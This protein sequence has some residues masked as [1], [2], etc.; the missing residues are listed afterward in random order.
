MI[1]SAYKNLIDLNPLVRVVIALIAGIVVGDCYSDAY[2]SWLWWL[3]LVVCLLLLLIMRGRKLPLCATPVK[4]SVLLLVA[5]FFLGGFLTV[6]HER[7]IEVEWPERNLSYEAICLSEPSVHGKVARVDLCIVRMDTTLLYE[8]IKVRAN[9]LRDT[10]TRRWSSLHVGDGIS[11]R[12]VLESPSNYR[13][14]TFDYVRWLKCHGFAGQ[15]FIYYTDWRQA[16]VSTIRLSSWQRVRLRSLRLRHKLLD[17]YRSMQ[18]E[19][20]AYG[21]IAAMTLGDKSSVDR[22]VKDQYSVS[23]GSHILALSGLHLSI[24]Y[25]LL[26]LLLGSGYRLMWLRQLIILIAVWTFVV[27][28][29]LPSSAVRSAVMLSLCSICMVGQRARVTVNALAF[30][31]IV[32]LLANPLTLWDIGFQMSFMAVLFI[33]V[34]EPL[35]LRYLR[36]SFPPLRWIWG[37]LSVS[38]VAQMGTAPLVAYYFGRFSCYFLL[39]NIFV[40]PLATVILYTTVL[41][42]LFTPWAAAQHF[43]ANLVGGMAHFMNA[44]LAYIASLPGASIENINLSLLQLYLIYIVLALFAVAFHTVSK[45]RKLKALDAFHKEDIEG[46]ADNF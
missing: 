10:L 40:I 45:V 2:P 7:D 5:V 30:A 34:F 20:E 32:L 9:I 15:T 33:L 46:L 25:G 1:P 36:P 12:S 43:I 21:V 26:F 13:Q 23:G 39:T 28:V 35:L 42:W 6:E 19:K 17:R 31:A 29:G 27:L 3:A 44:G 24:I 38:L 22:E 18:F 8:P 41:F 11:A 4:E 14:A 37:L 16:P